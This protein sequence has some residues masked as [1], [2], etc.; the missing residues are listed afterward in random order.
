[1]RGSGVL[2]LSMPW[3]QLEYPS[4]QLGILLSVLERAG[5]PAQTRSLNLDFM[6]HCAAATAGLAEDECLSLR[7]YRGIVRWSRDVSIGDWIFSTDSNG[8]GP[9]LEFLRETEVPETVVSSALRFRTP[10]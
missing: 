3:E 1:M 7:S 5:I 2:L 4:I 6:E 9:Y 8:D 10:V